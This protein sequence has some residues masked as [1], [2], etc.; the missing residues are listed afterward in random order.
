M[1]LARTAGEPM[2]KGAREMTPKLRTAVAA[3]AVLILISGGG[4]AFAQKP[5]GILKMYVWDNPPSMSMLDGVNPIGQRTTMEVFN[6]LIMFNQR[7]SRT[8]SNRSCPIWRPTG[9]GTR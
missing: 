7:V 2:N 5:G 6:N 1:R 8:A 3:S 9:P 4:A